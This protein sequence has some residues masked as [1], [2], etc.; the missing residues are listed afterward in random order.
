VGNAQVGQG[1]N[2]LQTFNF[3]LCLT[4]NPTNQI[5]IAPPA[6][7]A[8]SQY[9][10]F[11]R[12]IAARVAADGSVALN[13][14]IDVQTII[15]NGKTDINANGELSTDFVGYNATY[16]TNT[17]ASRQLIRQQ[18][19]DYIRGLLYFLA[20][21]S[22][23][24]VN[25][26]T[27][28]QSWALAKD[29]FQDSG[30]WP[31]QL[32]VREA[33]R[34]V[35]DY[36]MTQLHTDLRSVA[37]DP[38]ALAS[39]SVD[40][41]PDRRL[42]VAGKTQEEGGLG[43]TVTFPYGVSYRSIIPRAGECQNLFSTFALSASHVAYASI[44]M[45]PVFMM[46][47]QSAGT[48]A[49]FAIDDNVPV[50]QLNYQ[51]L[52]AQ[53]RADGQ[54]L[55]W[56]GAT[57]YTTNGIILD[58]GNVSGVTSSSGWTPGANS[59][60]WNGDYWH[61]GATG[62]GAKWVYYHPVLPTN[63]TYDVYLWWVES[64]NRAT[65]TPVDIIHAAGTNRVLVNQKLPSG[66]WFKVFSTNFNADSG[67]GVIIR[68]DNT[69]SGTYV[70][71]DGVRWMPVGNALP[72]P[73]PPP[74]PTVEIV[75][76]DAV[77]GEFGPDPGRFT[78]VRNN[79][80]NLL[81]VIVNYS[82]SGNASNGTSYAA[83]PGVITIPAGAP[84]TN[85]LVTPIADN[86]VEGDRTVT[87]TLL[88]STNYF[89][90]ALSNATLVLRDRPVDDWRLANFTT[91]QLNDPQISGALADPDRDGL[92]NLMEYALGLPPLAPEVNPFNP[93]VV[94]GYFQ[95]TYSRSKSATDVSLTVE[96]SSDLVTWQSGPAWFTQTG[97]VDQG[98]TQL[99]TVAATTPVSPATRAFIRL[100][101]T[102]L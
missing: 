9:Q 57:S 61:D 52:A 82:V 7:Y 34:M 30:G 28:M 62:K 88:A 39:Y 94:G 99:I 23:V 58:Q 47:S 90:D 71:A 19:E 54:L 22:Q 91:P 38:V 77:A 65:N 95:L 101:V 48:A 2:N 3:R 36:V 85:I 32:Y 102:R 70:I 42:A 78:L 63:G 27:N 6:G 97:I 29:E 96:Y 4:Q 35:S 13:Q 33:R 80:T 75:A 51:K 86:L 53:L 10:L 41:H 24:P 20:T 83:L 72:P 73:P 84:A 66:G 45:E 76:S 21:S 81:P 69:A 15:P 50:Q 43:G 37:P 17:Y 44:R 98:A 5:P 64:S 31:H 79:D 40:S 56:A 89:L 46:L 16:P 14:L 26:R 18:H 8:E 74:P 12:Y 93:R 49:A 100:R 60:G 25:V 11:A 92:S 68:N 67:A 87:L 55:V 59:G 1:D